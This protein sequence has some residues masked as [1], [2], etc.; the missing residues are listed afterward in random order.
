MKIKILTLAMDGRDGTRCRVFATEQEQNKYIAEEIILPDL[1]DD[2]GDVA[3]RIRGLLSQEEIDT[4]WRLWEDE[5]RNPEETFSFSTQE[6]EVDAF[7][8]LILAQ[9]DRGN[10]PLEIKHTDEGFII[11]EHTMGD[12]GLGAFVDWYNNRLQVCVNDTQEDEPALHVRYNQDGSIAE[13]MVRDDL[14]SVVKI[15]DGPT[16]EWQKERDAETRGES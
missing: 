4:A 8:G 1:I 16:T 6:I 2:D 3:C 11:P 10:A 13:I 7:R 12:T 5:K 14:M 9:G 15:M